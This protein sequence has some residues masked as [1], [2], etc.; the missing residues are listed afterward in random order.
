MNMKDHDGKY[1]DN[2]EDHA[3]KDGRR[4]VDRLG[5]RHPS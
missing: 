1:K 3:T 2:G 5:P 4:R